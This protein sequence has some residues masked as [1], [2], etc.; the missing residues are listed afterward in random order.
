M[1]RAKLV[2]IG[3]VA[4]IGLAVGVAAVGQAKLPSNVQTSDRVVVAADHTHEGS[5]YAT[6]EQI[7]VDGIVK[8]DLYCAGRELIVSG[9]VEGD[10][11]CAVQSATINGS[12]GQAIRL[13]GAKVWEYN[14]CR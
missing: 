4:S 3:F 1:Q 2:I 9:T 5:L 10:V 8:G 6:G 13:A 14:F 11:L 12:V 7:V